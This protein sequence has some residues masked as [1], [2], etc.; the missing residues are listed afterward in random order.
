MGNY[1]DNRGPG[2]LAL[3]IIALI[4]A[5]LAY[6]IMPA[7]KAVLPEKKK[8]DSVAVLPAETKTKVDSVY[9]NFTDKRYVEFVLHKNYQNKTY[10]CD[11]YLWV[12]GEIVADGN[13]TNLTPKKMELYK[14][15]VL[16]YYNKKMPEIVKVMN[17]FDKH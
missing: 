1:Y 5:G 16:G 6:L 13:E 17:D 4:I 8:A 2:I 12:D 7:P 14:K 9:P 15:K 10:D 3:F 11:Y